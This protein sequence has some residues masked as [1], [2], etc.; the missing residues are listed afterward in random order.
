VKGTPVKPPLRKAL[1]IAI[2][3]VALMAIAHFTINGLP[4]L[5][6]LNPH[7]R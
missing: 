5:G 4:A 2:A 3:I 1:Y 6:S 7:A